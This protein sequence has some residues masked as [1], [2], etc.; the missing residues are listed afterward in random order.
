MI[1][2]ELLKAPCVI[3]WFDGL[4]IYVYPGNE[5]SRALFLTGVYE[6]NELYWL[7][8]VLEPGKTFIDIGANMGVYSLFAATK[9]G[10]CGLVV[11]IEPSGRDFERLRFHVKLNRLTNVYLL[12]VA[13][14]NHKGEARL[15]VAPDK[16]SGHNTLGDFGYNGITPETAETVRLERVDDIVQSVGLQKVDFMKVD[17]EGAEFHVLQGAQDTLRLF[18]PTI[19]LELSDRT[20]KH[21]GCYSG[22]IWD[23][24]ALEGYRIY[25]FSEQTGLPVLAERRAYFDS[26]NVIAVHKTLEGRACINWERDVNT[27]ARS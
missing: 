23:F 25:R 7:D 19:L 18:H 6:P 10:S 9:V 2:W 24:L 15:L 22:Q 13:A 20:L 3:E 26:E 11:A 17:V 5:T 21:Q 16:N 14:S 8:K 4:R 27:V 12:Q 1:L